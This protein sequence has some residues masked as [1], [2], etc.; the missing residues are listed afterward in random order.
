MQYLACDHSCHLA[1][2]KIFT[3]NKERAFNKSIYG[4]YFRDSVKL[5]EGI[6]SGPYST[7]HKKRKI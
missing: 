1:G 6:G 3:H 4:S 2:F 7:K 5:I